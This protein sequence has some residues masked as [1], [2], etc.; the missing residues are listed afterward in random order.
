MIKRFS[1]HYIFTNINQPLR[2]GIVSVDD[3]GTIIDIEE[4]G[5]NLIEKEAVQFFDGIIIPGFVNCHCHLE[6]SHLH[7]KVPSGKGLGDFIMHIRNYREGSD[8]QTINAAMAAESAMYNE[9]V[10]LC[11]DICNTSLTFALKK[12]SKITWIN[13]LE[14]YGINQDRAVKRME[15]LASLSGQAR[16]FGLEYS[17][18]P[19]A[20][21]SVSLS[22]FSKIK[23]VSTNNSV[24]SIHFC[25]SEGEM[26]FIKSKNGPLMDSYINAG[27]LPPQVELPESHEDAILKEVTPSGNLILV[28]NTY[29]DREIIHKIRERNNIFWCLCPASNL[30]I[31]SVLPPVSLLNEEGCEI[32]VGTDSLASNNSLSMIGE[33]KLLQENFPSLT[34]HDLVRW[35]TINGAK[36]LGK[37]NEFGAIARGMRPGLILLENTD[38][39]NLRLLPETSVKRLV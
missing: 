1:A 22:L 7:S 17:V 16:A 23:A 37:H 9:G 27:L 24:T 5:G 26:Q 3:S 10:S 2:K 33:L 8:D 6:L 4:T 30:Y 31:E 12:R 32:V 21:Y 38:L 36:A 19:H 25:E 34:L 18:V 39:K 20:V 29:C 11:A 14:V 28:H 13:L 15:E 35:S